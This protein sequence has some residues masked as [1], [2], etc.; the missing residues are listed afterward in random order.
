VLSLL[1]T[2]IVV[3][4]ALAPIALFHF[5][6]QGL[7]GALANIVAIPLT[8]FVTMPLEALALAFDVVGLG[9]PFWWLTGQSL[10]LLLWIARSVAAWPG[11]VAALASVPNGAFA[12]IIG[13]GLWLLLW[14]GRVRLFGTLPIAIGAVWALLTPAPDL[15]ITGDGM[16]LAVRGDD[17]TL[18]TLRPRA[19]DYVRSVLGERSGELGDLTDLDDLA[20]AECSTD[21]CRIA[22][23]RGG[24]L[25]NVLAT[26]SRYRLPY[27]T[28]ANDCARADIVVSDRIL[29]R[30]CLPKWLKADRAI[31][32]ETGGLAITLSTGRVET[33]A[34]GQGVHPWVTAQHLEISNPVERPPQYRRN[35]PASRP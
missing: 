16:H 21:S 4:I 33:V 30:T 28:L 11:A 34:E 22:I 17:G 13:G 7:Y 31:L 25:W 9:A 5:H 24:R 15:L 10:D 12:A 19:G 35:R 6:R 32:S 2:G 1:V 8:T 3:E 26:R 14:S 20:G 29:P 18:A 27:E 23:T